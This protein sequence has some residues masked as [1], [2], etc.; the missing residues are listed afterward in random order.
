MKVALI[1]P[2]LRSLAARFSGGFH[3]AGDWLARLARRAP[4][5]FA[6]GVAPVD[7]SLYAP[8]RTPQDAAEHPHDHDGDHTGHDHP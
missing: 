1:Y 8:D 2:T 4:K 3:A 6:A 7:A 5:L